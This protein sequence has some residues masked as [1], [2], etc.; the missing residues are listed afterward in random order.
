VKILVANFGSTSFKYGL[1]EIDGE[2]SRRLGQGALERVTDYAAAVEEMAGRLVAAGCIASMDEVDAVGF[3]TVQGG[4]V[5][6][7][8]EADAEVLDALERTMDLAPAH[9]RPY[10]DGIR[11]FA[12]RYPGVRRAVLFETAFYQWVPEPAACYAVPPAWRKAGIR[13]YGFHG[14]SHKYVTE[15]IG[16]LTGRDDVAR[17]VRELY[18]SGPGTFAGPPFR[19]I[20]C[21]LGGSSSI[22]A[23]RDGL[24]IGTSM[25]LSPQSGVPQSNRVGDLDSAAIPYAMRTLRITLEEAERQLT[26]ESGLL[27]LSDG[28]SRDVRDLRAAAAEG[29]A[30]AALALDAL[31]HGIR[32]YIGGLH[33]ELGGLDALVFTGGI[34]ENDADLRD[35]VC[36]PLTHLGIALDAGLNCSGDG[37][38]CIST[39]ES[40]VA[41]W[42][43][44]TD[45]EQ[46]VAREVFRLFAGAQDARRHG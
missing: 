15:R 38:R 11:L 30:A 44:P 19:A 3:K 20:S 42:V 34:G 6:G 16:A 5:S 46:V 33:A 12:A 21:H 37:E 25:G 22:T 7:C 17:R 45:E 13:R 18:A 40:A 41:I 2:A 9:N 26:R 4:A 24:A 8:R 27:G 32:F 39:G 10:A 36:A 29:N 14:A 35:A 31:A 1:F 43:I 28:I 23:T